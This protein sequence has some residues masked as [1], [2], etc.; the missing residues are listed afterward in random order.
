MSD[1]HN[2]FTDDAIKA[3]NDPKLW[4]A[5]G[6]FAFGDNYKPITKENVNEQQTSGESSGRED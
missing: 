2:W 5:V 4:E 1:K 6:Y 3:L